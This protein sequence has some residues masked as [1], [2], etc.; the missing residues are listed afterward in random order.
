MK[1]LTV[2]ACLGVLTACSSCPV[3]KSSA[4]RYCHLQGGTLS[5]KKRLFG[6]TG[7]CTL[8]DGTRIEH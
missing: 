3:E 6:K 2:T 7:Y 5:Y 8:P 4:D 1:W